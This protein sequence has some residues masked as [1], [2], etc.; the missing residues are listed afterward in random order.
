MN[1][2]PDQKATETKT[3]PLSFEVA[4]D[5]LQT[6]VKKLE[7]GELSLEQSLQQFEEG[8]KLTRS[9]QEQLSAAEKRVE[10]LMK[11]NADGSVE[12]QPF[13]PPRG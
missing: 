11:A 9:C 13:A 4:L 8:V 2:A 12:L 7:S 10:L 5:Q 1:D 6:A 3:A